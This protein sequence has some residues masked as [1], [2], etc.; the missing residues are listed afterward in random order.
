MI[1]VLAAF[2][3]ELAAVGAVER[4]EQVARAAAG[5]LVGAHLQHLR[6]LRLEHAVAVAGAQHAQLA[7]QL[8]LVDEAVPAVVEQPREARA[9]RA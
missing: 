1:L 6:E 5:V 9:P 8:L 2:S 3:H 7:E 4:A